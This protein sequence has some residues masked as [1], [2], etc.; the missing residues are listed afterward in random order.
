MHKRLAVLADLRQAASATDRR[1]QVSVSPSAR[2]VGRFSDSSSNSASLAVA[3]RDRWRQSKPRYHREHS[4]RSAHRRDR[5]GSAHRA[6]ERFTS[7]SHRR[8]RRHHRHY[9]RR[10]RRSSRHHSPSAYDYGTPSSPGTYNDAAA[11]AAAA[12][13]HT[14]SRSGRRRRIGGV[15]PLPDMP[16]PTDRG[17]RQTRTTTTTG[18][19]NT[20]SRRKTKRKQKNKNKAPRPAE[21]DRADPPTLSKAA[22]TVAEVSRDLVQ[23][24]RKE[25]KEGTGRTRAGQTAA[26]A[27]AAAVSSAGRRSVDEYIRERSS[28]G[29]A[30]RSKRGLFLTSK[31]S[32]VVDIRALPAA[33]LSVAAA[34]Q[35]TTNVSPPP[36]PVAA[37]PDAV[38]AGSGFHTVDR[39]AG[40]DRVSSPTVA[41]VGPASRRSVSL[42]DTFAPTPPVPF[43]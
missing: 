16:E 39:G 17:N 4:G 36:R 3:T 2:V 8:R 31:V 38:I 32:K 21:S 42:E 30:H 11:A 23:Q 35:P 34:A 27:A 15:Q 9:H 33:L 26:A 28:S 41:H 18:N 22:G 5:R 13:V 19:H 7:S 10:R 37:V 43:G 1:R 25:S 14:R 40:A 24:P 29:R 6:R 20:A 12:V